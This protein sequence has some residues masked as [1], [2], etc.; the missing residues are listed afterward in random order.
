MAAVKSNK[1]KGKKGQT[2]KLT[3]AERKRRKEAKGQVEARRGSGVR[4]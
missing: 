3:S 2:H 4:S 1:G